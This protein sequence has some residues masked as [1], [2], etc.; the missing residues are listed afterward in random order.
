MS[1]TQRITPAI[2]AGIETDPVHGSVV[3]PLYLSSNFTFEELG[4]TR[5]FDYTRSGNPTRAVLSAAIA[6]LEGGAGATIAATGMGAI[7]L[8]LTALLE[9]GDTVVYPNDC[10]GGTW[11]LFTELGQKGLYTFVKADFTDPD[12]VERTVAEHEPKIVWCE[13]PSN[14]LLRITDIRAVAAI[15]QRHNALL[16]AD[17]T[18]LTPVGQSPFELGADVVVHSVTKYLNG[19]SDVV[20][21]AVVA[22]DEQGAELFD[23]WGNVLGITASPADSYLTL[24]GLRTLEV[25]FA[26]HQQ[27]AKEL[28]AA[29]ADHPALSTIHFPG[30]PSHPGHDIAAAQ[31]RGFGAMFSVELAGGEASVRAFL[32]GLRYFSLAESLGGTESLVAHPDTMTH[33]SMTPEARADAGITSGLLRFS[34]G[35]EPVEDL[36]ADLK[37]ALDRAAAA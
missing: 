26:K 13:T 27:N 37:E 15:A 29:I 19:H 18:F 28:V 10:Y 22:K 8:A 20:Q 32:D 6:H 3:P 36:I 9:P 31:Q 33:A 21:G 24:R 23:Y 12:G 1:H 7:T 17:N 5:E 25:R 16:V 4:K 14:P 35:I 34:V 2:R 30:L 11:R